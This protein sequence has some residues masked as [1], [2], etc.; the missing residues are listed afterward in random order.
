MRTPE[1]RGI[2]LVYAKKPPFRQS[3]LFTVDIDKMVEQGSTGTGWSGAATHQKV[4]DFL[5]TTWNKKTLV[6]LSS[7]EREPSANNLRVEIVNINDLTDDF[8]HGTPVTKG[9]ATITIIEPVRVPDAN[10]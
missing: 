5:K 1:L 7:N 9:R 2:T 3:W 10:P 4:W 6:Q 8:R